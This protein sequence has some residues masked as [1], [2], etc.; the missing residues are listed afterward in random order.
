MSAAD[1][2]YRGYRLAVRAQGPGWRVTIYAPGSVFG[3]E[4]ISQTSDSAGREQVIAD[5]RRIV[6]RLLHSD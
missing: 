2:D 3:E 1:L 4:E 5:A 6:D